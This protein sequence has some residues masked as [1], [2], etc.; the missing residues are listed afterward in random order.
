[1]DTYPEEAKKKFQQLEEDVTKRYK[2]YE[3]Y[4]KQLEV[5]KNCNPSIILVTGFP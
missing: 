4:A 3:S 2:K 1:M 5:K